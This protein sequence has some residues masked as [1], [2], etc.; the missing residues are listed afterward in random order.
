MAT[1]VTFDEMTGEAWRVER[2]NME[3]EIPLQHWHLNDP[4]VVP[5]MLTRVLVR[6][7][8]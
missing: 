2:T 6:Q 3:S 7:P 4:G 5:T 8:V 1:T